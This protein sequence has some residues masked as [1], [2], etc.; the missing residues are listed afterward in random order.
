MCDNSYDDHFIA[1]SVEKVE[2]T[3]VICD[4]GSS[5]SSSF[6]QIS[7]LPS[8]NNTIHSTNFVLDQGS[9]YG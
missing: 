8:G 1:P 4:A 5:V 7:N 3:T 9:A 2:D 6:P